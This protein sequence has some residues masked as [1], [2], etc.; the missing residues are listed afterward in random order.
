M[1]VSDAINVKQVRQFLGLAGYFRKFVLNFA[2]KVAPLTNLF[3]KNFSW[4]WGPEQPNAVREI[5]KLLSNRPVLA[6]FDPIH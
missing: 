5:K 6:I 1:E 3:K 2:Q 4:Q